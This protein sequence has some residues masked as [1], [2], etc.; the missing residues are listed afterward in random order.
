MGVEARMADGDGAVMPVPDV[1]GVRGA[2]VFVA[3]G[4]PPGP[5]PPMPVP[6][7]CGDASM[8]PLGS[9]LSS[10]FGGPPGV[11]AAIAG[12]GCG[13]GIMAIG[14]LPGIMRG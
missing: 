13:G 12:E 8:R 4:I 5:G 3:E 7:C 6:A 1:F 2:G 11:F 10:G 14:G 9:P